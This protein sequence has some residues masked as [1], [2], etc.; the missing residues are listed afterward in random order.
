VATINCAVAALRAALARDAA[1]R[2]RQLWHLR[3]HR[4]GLRS[5][6][7]MFPPR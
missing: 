3:L 2:E 5:Q 4:L 7:D 6:R 1:E